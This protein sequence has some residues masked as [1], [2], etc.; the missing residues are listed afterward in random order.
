MR[1]YGAVKYPL[2]LYPHLGFPE[3]V[4]QFPVQ[5]FVPEFPVE[6]FTVTIFPRG[7]GCDVDRLRAKVAKLVTQAHG[8]HFRAVFGTDVQGCPV[9]PSGWLPHR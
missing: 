1:S 4:K 2:P 5:Q 8:G 3:C 7:V 9:L 6:R